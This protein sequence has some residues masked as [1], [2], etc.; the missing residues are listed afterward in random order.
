MKWFIR[1]AVFVIALVVALSIRIV[2]QSQK[3]DHAFRAERKLALRVHRA[4]RSYMMLHDGRSPTNWSQGTPFLS[5]RSPANLELTSLGAVADSAHPES[6]KYVF[7]NGVIQSPH[8]PYP[9]VIMMSSQAV[10]GLR[11][12]TFERLAICR[13]GDDATLHGID[14]AVVIEKY[15]QVGLEVPRIADGIP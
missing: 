10:A 8:W 13:L 4:V 6:Q 3:Y 11:R 12:G 15:K 1:F 5:P 2:V 9:P 7:V 14:E